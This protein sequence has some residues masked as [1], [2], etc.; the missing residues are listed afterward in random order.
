MR[1]CQTVRGGAQRHISGIDAS[2]TAPRSVPALLANLVLRFPGQPM[3]NEQ[4]I[5]LPVSFKVK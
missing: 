5:G 2:P 4:H 3:T 1:G